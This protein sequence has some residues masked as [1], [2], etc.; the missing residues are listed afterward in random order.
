MIGSGFSSAT[1][2]RQS[3]M[4]LVGLDMPNYALIGS[5]VGVKNSI[6]YHSAYSFGAFFQKDYG[7]FGW[8]KI[9][10]GL[11]FGTH[12]SQRSYNDGTSNDKFTDWAAGPAFR[13]NWEVLPTI[14]IGLECLYGIRDIS[15]VQLYSQR[16]VNFVVGVRF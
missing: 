5:A 7:E 1:G 10:S 3:P 15:F 9:R 12:V 4:L 14:V 8:G 2:G 6:Y 11:G 13:I 16:V